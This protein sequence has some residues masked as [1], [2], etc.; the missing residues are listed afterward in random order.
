MSNNVQKYKQLDQREHVLKRPDSYMGSIEPDE[1]NN[2]WL[3]DEN[4]EFIRKNVIISA[5]FIKIFDEI[6][7][8]ASDQCQKTRLDFFSDPKVQVTKSIKVFSI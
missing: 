2:M 7:T 5:G 6:L 3:C 1:F 8:N 4:H